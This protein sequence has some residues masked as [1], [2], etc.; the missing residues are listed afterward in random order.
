MAIERAIEEG[1]IDAEIDKRDDEDEQA[2][3]DLPPTATLP[4][5]EEKEQEMMDSLILVGFPKE[6]Y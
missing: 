2:R 1:P 4:S 5:S 6:E 3:T